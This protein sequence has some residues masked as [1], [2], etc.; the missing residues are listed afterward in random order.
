MIHYVIA[1]GNQRR[2][3]VDARQVKP[4]KMVVTTITMNVNLLAKV[5][6][7]AMGSPTLSPKLARKGSEKDN[8][9]CTC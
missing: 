2:N 8:Q 6:L 5:A 1:F 7:K 3:H 4:K 9:H